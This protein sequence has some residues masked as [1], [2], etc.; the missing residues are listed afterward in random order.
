VLQARPL[1]GRGCPGERLEPSIHL[2]RVA[3]DGNGV[4]SA[5]TQK[6][7]DGDCDR[8]FTDPGRAEYRQ[9]L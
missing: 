6:L 3:R 2:D 1:T 4:L 5:P 8:R 9:D 7:G